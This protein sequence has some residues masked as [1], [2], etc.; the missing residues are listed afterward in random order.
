MARIEASAVIDRPI[1]EV[2]AYVTDF[3]NTPLWNAEVVESKKT[4]EGPV[5]VG[6]KFDFA[7]K[8][9]GRQVET[10]G[11]VAE[12][13]PNRKY[14][15]KHEGGPIS[16]L[17][18]VFTFEPVEGGTKITHVAEVETGGFFRLAEPVVARLTKR[19]WETNFATLQDL[20]E[21][22]AEAGA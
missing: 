1:D 15:L 13:E 6:A 12:Y 22:Q 17:S 20:L 7:V 18:D 10:A 2:F 19:Q 8:L 21:A 9:L 5:G 11:E 16:I 4:S 3:A 14:A